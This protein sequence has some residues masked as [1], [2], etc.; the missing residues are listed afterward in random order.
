MSVVKQLVNEF[1]HTHLIHVSTEHYT[2]GLD[3]C[4]ENY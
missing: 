2:F 3:V 1:C 4:G